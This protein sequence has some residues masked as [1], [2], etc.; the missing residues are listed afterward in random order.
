MDILTLT[1][2][3]RRQLE[4]QLRSATDARVYRRTLALLDVGGGES[5][6]A[7]AARLRVTARIISRWIGLYAR[8]HDPAAVPDRDRP[9]RPRR[10]TDRGRELLGE[11]LT[12]SPQDV[13]GFAVAWTVPLLCRQLARRLRRRPSADTV[14]REL[15]RLGYT[16]KRSR[17]VLAPDPDAGGK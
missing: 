13:G 14:R 15:R 16:W 5:I 8:D 4:R 17:Y 3:Q 11:L 12:R 6:A 9:G 7:V 2:W 10:M 1:T